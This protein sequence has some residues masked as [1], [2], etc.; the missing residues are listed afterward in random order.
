M[1]TVSIFINS[2]AKENTKG[3]WFGLVLPIVI[4]WG[5]SLF[6]LSILTLHEG[7]VSEMT[8]VEYIFLTFWVLGHLVIWPLFAWWLFRRAVRL[9]NK[10][11]KKGAY[12]SMKLYTVWLL[13]IILP[14]TI[15]EFMER[16]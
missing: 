8:Y 7:P 4:G 12:M 16:T 3:Y 10:S 6:S 2:Q 11:C 9:E 15:L 14:E 1:I 13:F 5:V